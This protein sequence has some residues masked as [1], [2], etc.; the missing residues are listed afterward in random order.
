ME[1]GEKFKPEDERY[2]AIVHSGLKTKITKA[3]VERGR[4]GGN[5][6]EEARLCV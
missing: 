2:A 4:E 6:E 1:W 5:S 3:S